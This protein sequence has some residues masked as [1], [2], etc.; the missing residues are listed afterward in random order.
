M[1]VLPFVFFQLSL[2][3]GTY[4]PDGGLP[5]L[6]VRRLRLSIISVP[7]ILTMADV[8]I[9]GREFFVGYF[10]PRIMSSHFPEDR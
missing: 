1:C 3:H 8:E 5:Q 2:S 6:F 10:K 7:G 4:Q 9:R